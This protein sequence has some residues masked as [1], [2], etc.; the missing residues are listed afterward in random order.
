MCLDVS[1][2]THVGDDGSTIMFSNV[3]FFAGCFTSVV[4]ILVRLGDQTAWRGKLSFF[5]FGV[6][7]FVLSITESGATCSVVYGMQQPPNTCNNCSDDLGRIA[8]DASGW[9]SRDRSR[10]ALGDTSIWT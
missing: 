10:W 3:N 8:C 9:T 7:F 1:R 5:Y 6:L 2:P 4:F